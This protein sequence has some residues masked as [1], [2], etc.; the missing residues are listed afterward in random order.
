M[1]IQKTSPENATFFCYLLSSCTFYFPFVQRKMNKLYTTVPA[2]QPAFITIC[3]ICTTDFLA[4]L[5][6]Y[7]QQRE[8]KLLSV[9]QKDYYDG[10]PCFHSDY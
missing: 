4:I 2:K 9:T 7:M 1:A 6:R 10:T 8:I 3:L 5:L